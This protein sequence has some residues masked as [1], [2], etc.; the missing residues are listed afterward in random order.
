M[1]SPR[2]ENRLIQLIRMG[3]S[4]HTSHKWVNILA[5]QRS[6]HKAYFHAGIHASVTVRIV[7]VCTCIMHVCVCARVTEMRFYDGL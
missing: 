6:G 2:N 1:I 3:K 5:V 4:I 7:C